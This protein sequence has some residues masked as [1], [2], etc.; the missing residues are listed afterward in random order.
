MAEKS[1]REGVLLNQA[2]L[3]A[4]R[5]GA[6][7]FRNQRG[8]YRATDGRWIEYG[9]AHG[10]SDLIGWRVVTITPDMIGMRLA[11]FVAIECKS[12]RRALTAGQS[13]FVNTV[14]QAGGRAG[15]VRTIDEVRTLFDS[16]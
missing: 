16:N 14:E 10:A 12:G 13:A 11:Q 2:R 15:V 1:S 9:L 5:H 6:R 7:L 3:Y 4:S 8:K